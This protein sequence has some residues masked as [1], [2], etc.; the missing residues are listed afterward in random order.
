MLKLNG[1]IYTK[2][3]VQY[4]GHRSIRERREERRGEKRNSSNFFHVLVSWEW[5]NNI[6]IK[7]LSRFVFFVKGKIVNISDPP[8]PNH[9]SSPPLK[10]ESI[11]R[12][13]NGHDCV[14]IKPYQK[15]KK[16]RFVPQDIVCQPTLGLKVFYALWLYINN[17][18]NLTL[19]SETFQL[20]MSFNVALLLIFY[21]YLSKFLCSA[22]FDHNY[23]VVRN[24]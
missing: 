14:P 24:E 21:C 17:L 11:H 8:T 2:F 6:L 23:N 13:K 19:Q 9:Y 5:D 18:L 4:L 22:K 3:L 1:R 20:W 10:K 12:Q 16:A 7:T 15:R